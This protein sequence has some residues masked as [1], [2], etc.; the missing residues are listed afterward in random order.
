MNFNV[1]LRETELTD[2]F[3]VRSIQTALYNICAGDGIIQSIMM[4]TYFNA[5]VADA[6]FKRLTPRNKRLSD[7][8]GIDI[9]EI[10]W[11]EPV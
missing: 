1:L 5:K 3:C 2:I 7:R 6:V 9:M 4:A 11:T 8:H 10:V